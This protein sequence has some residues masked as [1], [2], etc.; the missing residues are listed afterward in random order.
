MFL[1]GFRAVFRK[2]FSRNRNKAGKWI[3]KIA[4]RSSI[5]RE[6]VD[7]FAICSDVVCV[8]WEGLVYSK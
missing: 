8:S 6:G 1:V 5:A 4:E 7:G 3:K 2:D